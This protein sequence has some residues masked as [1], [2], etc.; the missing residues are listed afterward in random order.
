M[1]ITYCSSEGRT[2]HETFGCL[3]P[4]GHTGLHRAS[5]TH[6][7]CPNCGGIEDHSDTCPTKDLMEDTSQPMQEV[8]W[9][10]DG[11][12]RLEPYVY[13]PGRVPTYLLTRRAKATAHHKLTIGVRL[14][15]GGGMYPCCSCGW[16]GE[17]S[18]D[19][20]LAAGEWNHHYAKETGRPM[21][22]DEPPLPFTTDHLIGHLRHEAQLVLDR[23]LVTRGQRLVIRDLLLR[24]ADEIDRLKRLEP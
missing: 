22:D 14:A 18:F 11:I 16:T 5:V 24:A 20:E 8:V 6:G 2:G 4:D 10:D 15:H 7:R 12:A 23:G 3:N 21:A 19:A 13:D 17:R 1:T 9:G